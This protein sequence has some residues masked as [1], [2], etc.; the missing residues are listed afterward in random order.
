[1]EREQQIIMVANEALEQILTY[2]GQ[3]LA[4]RDAAEEGSPEWVKRNGEILGYAKMTAA[5][6]KLERCC[7]ACH[8]AARRPGDLLG[9]YRVAG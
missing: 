6:D 8:A 1:M 7:K 3:A 2:C 4:A 5:L 9:G